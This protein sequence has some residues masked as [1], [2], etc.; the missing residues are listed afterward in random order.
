[1]SRP[2]EH[3]DDATRG[4]PATVVARGVV[5]RGDIEGATDL[6]VQ[7][8][9]L[10]KVLVADLLLDA[11]G[12]IEGS[13]RAEAVVIGGRMVGPVEAETVHLAATASVEGDV[14]CRSIQ[15]DPGAR[16]TGRCISDEQHHEKAAVFARSLDGASAPEDETEKLLSLAARLR[17]IAV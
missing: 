1:M 7:G 5:F 3:A 14:T 4:R 15:I 10:G 9:V 16:F 12:L 8:Q 11:D 6:Q 2:S 13:V 17:R